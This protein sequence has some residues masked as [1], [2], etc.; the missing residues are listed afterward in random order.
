[1]KKLFL[2]ALLFAGA[3]LCM[4]KPLPSLVV[5]VFDQDA[6]VVKL[7]DAVRAVD[8]LSKKQKTKKGVEL[9]FHVRSD[10]QTV[11]ATVASESAELQFRSSKSGAYEC[12]SLKVN[13]KELL[14]E[15]VSVAPK[16][17]SEKRFMAEAA[18]GK[19]EIVVE[20]R[21]K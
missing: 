21:M 4:A 16:Q 19:M 11:K 12:R 18:N 15:T 8:N 1:M 7:E 3:I 14:T 6:K 2:I 5:A 17:A 10:W 9:F 13:G 20:A